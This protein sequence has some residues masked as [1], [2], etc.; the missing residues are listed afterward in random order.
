M[1]FLLG[2][3]QFKSNTLQ[4]YHKF[5]K[6]AQFDSH[7]LQIKTLPHLFLNSRITLKMLPRIAFI[8]NCTL[9]I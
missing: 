2:S 1:I 9:L 5:F 7:K 4:N 8:Y 3:V 6:M